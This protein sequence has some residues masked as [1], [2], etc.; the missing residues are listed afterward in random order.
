MILW[1]TEWATILQCKYKHL[2]V[3]KG[4]NHVQVCSQIKSTQIGKHRNNCRFTIHTYA[5]LLRCDRTYNRI[6]IEILNF[7]ETK[8]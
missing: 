8:T 7:V 6:C 1:A 4:K 3:W 5:K 2:E